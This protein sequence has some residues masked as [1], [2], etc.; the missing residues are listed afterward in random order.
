MLKGYCSQTCC[1]SAWSLTE[2][3]VSLSFCSWRNVHSM[4]LL[5]GCNCLYSAMFWCFWLHISRSLFS[6]CFHHCSFSC[7]IFLISRLSLKNRG[8]ISFAQSSVHLN[9]IIKLS[10]RLHRGLCVVTENNK[11][12]ILISMYW[13][14]FALNIR[15][16]FYV[17]ICRNKT[18]ICVIAAVL[19]DG[20]VF[21]I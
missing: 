7:S 17:I 16:T 12:T 11:N 2:P 13:L 1:M 18:T 6:G 21:F 20:N 4:C 9:V 14:V 19:T 10:T 15:K 5:F 3:V 8:L